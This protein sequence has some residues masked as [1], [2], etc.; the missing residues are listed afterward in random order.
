MVKLLET[1]GVIEKTHV[2]LCTEHGPEQ[3]NGFRFMY[4]SVLC[5]YVPSADYGQVRRRDVATATA[6]RTQRSTERWNRSRGETH[7]TFQPKIA[8]V[9]FGR[10]LILFF[11]SFAQFCF[12]FVSRVILINNWCSTW[13]NAK[14]LMNV[15]QPV[16]VCVC[17]VYPAPWC[18]DVWTVAV[19]SFTYA[20]SLRIQ[21]NG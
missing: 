6:D 3:K 13:A 5:V 2:V 15:T 1:S 17:L 12:V 19:S 8:A 10:I 20:P 14:C 7:S 21:R 9:N 18:M 16:C 4:A 11:H